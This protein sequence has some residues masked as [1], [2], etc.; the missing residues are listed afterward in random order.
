MD[1][2]SWALAKAP[3][4]PNRS[5]PPVAVVCLLAQ[6]PAS[7]QDH[8]A[9]H[10]MR[11]GKNC[12]LNPDPAFRKDDWRDVGCVKGAAAND[13]SGHGCLTKYYTNFTFI[14]GGLDDA[15]TNCSG[16]GYPFGSKC[17]S[18][19]TMPADSP[20]RTQ[21]HADPTGKSGKINPWWAPGT[22]PIWSPW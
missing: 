4:A 3:L 8:Y 16:S 7:W 21:A 9:E 19:P 5:L 6:T 10:A 2:H 14:P 15:V 12:G 17:K 11:C 22:A 1:F 20:L 18:K 13:W